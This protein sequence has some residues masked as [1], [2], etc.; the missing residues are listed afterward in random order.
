MDQLPNP[1]QIIEGVFPEER[2][3]FYRFLRQ[4]KRRLRFWLFML[5]IAA[6]Y[7]ILRNVQVVVPF[8]FLN[9]QL[10]VNWIALLWIVSVAAL[11]LIWPER[12]GDYFSDRFKSGLNPRIWEFDGDWKAELD[13]NA[14]PTLSVTNSNRG[15]LA[16]PCLAWSDYEVL[17]E[18]RI[19]HEWTGWI[20]RASSLN[21]YVH[22]KLGPT[23]L[24]T[25]YRVSGF[26]L[27]VIEI[28]HGQ[29]IEAMT[30]YQIRL[31][32]RGN[33]LSVY[34]K[35]NGKERLLFQ[36]D[37]LG[38]QPP[39]EV[40]FKG[41]RGEISPSERRQLL[42]PNYRAGSFGFRLFGEEKAHFRN[43]KAYR[44]R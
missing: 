8:V 24:H 25:H 28:T 36:K 33:W 23:E 30:W 31:L 18:S 9:S 2:R 15:G 12:P 22:Q 16:L 27:P 1:I 37:V 35:V 41:K 3:R 13:E 43:L 6:T 11:P 34:V 5:V 38:V 40:E 42:V 32:A 39:I 17:F 4:Q 21:D 14:K 20:I 29:P 10:V 19:V 44:L 7:L 26:L